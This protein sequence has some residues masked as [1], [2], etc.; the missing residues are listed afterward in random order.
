[1]I[2]LQTPRLVLRR[3]RDD[4]IV[5]M[6]AINADPEVMRWIGPGAVRDEQ[7]T[8][9]G[10]ERLE[11]EWDD[12]GYG[13]FAVQIRA[14]GDLAG[15]AG[16]AIPHFLPEIMPAVEIAWRLGHPYWGQGIGTEAAGAALSFALA[17]CDLD[18]IV[19]IVQIG[20]GAS[21]RIMR[22]LGMG[23]ERET[24]DPTSGRPVRVYQITR[25]EYVLA[26]RL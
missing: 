23:L 1:M 11:R 18:R 24:V 16:M 17:R 2:I 6:A 10:I 20:N 4:D 9:A 8:R 14:T 25:A 19:A 3:W 21:E 5:P 13:I 22:K 26:D 15:F 12:Q 7:Q